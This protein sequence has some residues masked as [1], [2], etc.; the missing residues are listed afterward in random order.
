M[1]ASPSH[2][3]LSGSKQVLPPFKVTTLTYRRL[4]VTLCAAYLASSFFNHNAPL[5]KT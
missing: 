5:L 4:I 3:Y 1:E 2:S